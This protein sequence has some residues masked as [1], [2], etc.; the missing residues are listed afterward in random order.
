MGRGA[1][2]AT[3]AQVLSDREYVLGMGDNDYFLGDPN[4]YWSEHSRLLLLAL[5]S[6]LIPERSFELRIV[7]ALPVTLYTRENREQVKKALEGYYRFS[8]ST[9]GSHERDREVTIKVGYVGMEG[10]GILVH[11]GDASSEQAVFDIGERT[12]GLIVA[13][14]QKLLVSHCYGNKELGVRLLV[15][16]LQSL[17]KQYRKVI[18][19]DKAHEIL[20]A[21]A[22][23]EPLPP[24]QWITEESLSNEI[25]T[26]IQPAGR[27]LSNFISQHL[28][29]D[30]ETVAGSFDRV[31]LAG[32]GVYL[33][34]QHH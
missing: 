30:G 13:S 27:A 15:D 2:D 21:Y 3:L 24:L 17:A 22:N 32:G 28:T 8:F 6:I 34:S 33:L 23:N 31:Y 5:A 20:Y 18:K 16:D 11:C 14:G 26:S 10:Q 29:S 9:Q 1:T 7:T 19:T 12:F 4:R 25:S